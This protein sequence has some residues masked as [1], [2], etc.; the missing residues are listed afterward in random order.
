MLHHLLPEFGK[1]LPVYLPALCL[2][3][4]DVTRDFHDSLKKKL[5]GISMCFLKIWSV[6]LGLANHISNSLCG[7]RHP[8]SRCQYGDMNTCTHTFAVQRACCVVS[9]LD[10]RSA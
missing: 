2:T 5:Q 6:T 7:L 1:E 8:F 10:M 3:L 9:L 4:T